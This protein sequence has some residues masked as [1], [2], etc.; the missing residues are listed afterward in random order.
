VSKL[1]KIKR[2]KVREAFLDNI[3]NNLYL[4]DR[5]TPGKAGISPCGVTPFNSAVL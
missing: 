2:H 3:G 1:S 5:A 4:L